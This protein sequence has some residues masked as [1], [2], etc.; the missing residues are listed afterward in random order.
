MRPA[1]DSTIMS[2][3]PAEPAA[4]APE[5][6]VVASYTAYL[7]TRTHA[8][9]EINIRGDQAEVAVTA[10]DKTLVL[11]FRQRSREWALHN[12][13]LRRGAHAVTFSRGQLT[14]AVAALLGP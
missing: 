3:Q 14:E 7:R 12:A 6:Q 11:A 9:P 1:R 4:P 2:Q 13:R 5:P 8:D 10:G